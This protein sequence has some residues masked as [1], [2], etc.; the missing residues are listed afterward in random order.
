MRKP[1]KPFI[2]SHRKGCTCTYCKGPHRMHYGLNVPP[3]RESPVSW[4]VVKFWPRRYLR[5]T[6]Q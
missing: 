2:D 1:F 4:W 5:W 6:M 3:D